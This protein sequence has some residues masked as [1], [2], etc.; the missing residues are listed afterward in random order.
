ML[1]KLFLQVQGK[2]SKGLEGRQKTS[3][4]LETQT[5]SKRNFSVNLK[6]NETKEVTVNKGFIP[7]PFNI[8]IHQNQLSVFI[9]HEQKN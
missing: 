5:R 8:Y 3:K 4:G 6:Y 2:T 7:P 9:N 1:S